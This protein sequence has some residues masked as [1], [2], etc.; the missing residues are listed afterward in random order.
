M[1]IV[2]LSVI[3]KKTTMVKLVFLFNFILLTLVGFPQVDAG[4][5]L[6]ISSGLPIELNGDYI[7]TIGIP[8][9]ATDDGYVGPFDVGFDFV[10]FGNTYN[11]FAIGPNGLISFDVP[12]IIGK[13][14]FYEVTLPTHEPY[15]QKAILGP[16][17]DL[18]ARPIA[19][20]DQYI[21]YKTVGQPGDRKLIVGW[22][23]APMFGCSA[24]NA[25]YQIVL[26]ENNNIIQNHI[27]SK[28]YCNTNSNLATQGLNLHG[29]TAVAV[30]GRNGQSF[31]VS[32]E[33]WEFVP[34][35]PDNYLVD[36][37]AFKPEVIV[38][39]GKLSWA[40]YKNSYPNGEVISNE[41]SVLVSPA[42]LTEYFC[43]IT[44]CSGLKYVDPVTIH[45]IPIPN[46]FNPNSTAMENRE[47]KLYID[48]IMQLNNFAFYIYDRWGQLVFETNDI[49]EGWDGTQNDKPCN[50]GVYVWTVFYEGEGG[51]A[52]NKGKVTL[53]K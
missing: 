36:S 49:N 20:H 15:F 39:I 21:Y 17:Q 30:P 44:T 37:L 27:I 40:W 10:F 11:Q 16:Y 28:P 31:T 8:V 7:G 5:D 26:N 25:S 14:F 1:R 4:P 41:Q 51:K 33:S 18:F 13:S 48:P 6:T 32:L 45:V 2:K 50:A 43:E 29:T 34:D 3:N 42:E 19:P 52:T 38:P 46:A 24:E 35:G 12:D 23:D 9:T 22:C 47:F 53:V